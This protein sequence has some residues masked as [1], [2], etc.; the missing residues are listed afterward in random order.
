MQRMTQQDD[1]GIATIFF[2]LLMV[3][4]VGAMSLA[5]DG[6]SIF[7]NKQSDQNGADAA[8]LAIALSCA[9]AGPCSTAVGNPYINPA[10]STPG[11][12]GQVLSAAFGTG[13]V[14]ATVTKVVDTTFGSAIGVDQGTTQRS[15]TAKWGALGSATGLFPITVG[16]CAFTIQFDIKVTLHSYAVPGCN[17]PAGQFGFIQGGCVSQTIV[18]GQ[19]L[20]GTTGNNLGGTCPNPEAALNSML[21]KD[22]LIPVW[23]TSAGQGAGATYHVLSYAVFNFQGWSTNG[24]QNHGGTL[25]AMC[26]GTLDG[27]PVLPDTGDKNKPCVR[28]VFKGFSVQ[29]G[30]V[31]PG[32]S[33]KDNLLVCFVYLD[34]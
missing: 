16:T 30:A 9:N 23:D 25:Q 19:N 7:S 34:H 21:G 13:E 2:V 33:C 29:S 27:D 14:T 17:N 24:G 11:R 1:Q 4:M 20:P 8:A 3:V 5:I 32:L 18:A 12:E 22:V 31:V 15:A 6:G 26:D 10:G 28:G